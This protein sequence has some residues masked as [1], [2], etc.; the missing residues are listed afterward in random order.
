MKKGILLAVVAAVMITPAAAVASHHPTG[1]K[2]APKVMYVLH[3]KLSAYTPYD[4][5]IYGP[6]N[7]S[8]TIDIT[9]A[10]HHGKTLKTMTLTF[11]VG[12]TTMISLAD[13]VSAISDG[14]MGIVKI[15]AAKRIA[16]ADL[17]ATLQAIPARQIVD[18]GPSS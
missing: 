18:Q 5:S 12:P 3:G 13:G 8:I 14:D 11:P 17:A 1:G 10:N 9:H 4:D 6:V 16:P 2:S 15:K 7:G